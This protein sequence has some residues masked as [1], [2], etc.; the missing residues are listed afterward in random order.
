MKD[1]IKKYFLDGTKYENHWA[2]VNLETGKE[3]FKISKKNSID[4]IL[5]Q[6]PDLKIEA[7]RYREKCESE[8]N[9]VDGR[10][11]DKDGIEYESD[12]EYYRIKAEKQKDQ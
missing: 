4:D 9:Y 7:G 8:I 3:I 10:W 1:E 6:F 2:V 5:K 12:D 11:I